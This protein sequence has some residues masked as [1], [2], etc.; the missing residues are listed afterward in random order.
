MQSNEKDENKIKAF[1]F[2]NRLPKDTDLTEINYKLFFT[3]GY[4]SCY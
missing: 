1:Q 3:V 4:I 2:S